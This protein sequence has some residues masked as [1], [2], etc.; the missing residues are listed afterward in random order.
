[1]SLRFPPKYCAYSRAI[2]KPYPV[3]VQQCSQYN[4]TGKEM[5]D[6]DLPKPA[7]GALKSVPSKSCSKFSGLAVV[8][9]AVQHR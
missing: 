2:G 3:N 8:Y 6:F 5:V 4:R 7:I 1:M 9:L